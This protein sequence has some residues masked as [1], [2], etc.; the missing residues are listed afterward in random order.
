M[1]RHHGSWIGRTN[2]PM[3]RN[4]VVVLCFECVATWLLVIGHDGHDVMM[5]VV[6]RRCVLVCCNKTQAASSRLWK[7][8]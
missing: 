3:L 4:V 8:E 1:R 2:P 7:S 5:V 6:A